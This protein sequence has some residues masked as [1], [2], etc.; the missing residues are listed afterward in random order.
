MPASCAGHACAGEAREKRIHDYA[1]VARDALLFVGAGRRAGV[2]S[3]GL[4]CPRAGGWSGGPAA[5]AAG[6]NQNTGVR[7]RP[8]KTKK[9]GKALRHAPIIL[10]A[11]PKN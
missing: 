9:R 1:G 11:S 6:N 8:L 7:K 10:G 3:G 5:G 2:G 4:A